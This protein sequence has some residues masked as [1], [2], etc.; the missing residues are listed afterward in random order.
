MEAAEP[1]IPTNTAAMKEPDTPPTY[2]PSSIAKLKF[3]FN[4]NVI[5][6]IRAIPRPPER[7]GIAP[8]T[9][10]TREHRYIMMKFIG[11]NKTPSAER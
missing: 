9:Q 10:P 5:G 3:V 2:I 7:P 8:S 6:R 11:W 1:G 4:A